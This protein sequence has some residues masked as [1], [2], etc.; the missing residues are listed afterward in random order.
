MVLTSILH[1]QPQHI[2]EKIR[3]QKIAYITSRINLTEQEAQKFWPV[4]NDF[5]RKKEDIH[6]RKR[7]I[8]KNLI[9]KMD[10]LSS[11]QK[12][13]MLDEIILLKKQ[14]AELVSAYHQKFKQVL[15]IEKV[16]L[17]YKAEHEFKIKLMKQ[18]QKR[19]H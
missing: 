8:M 16:V 5:D 15:P 14:E 6:L 19:P 2:K 3:S 10:T 4:Y 11:K 7:I 9:E 1:A 17:L 13:Q 18:L 12:E